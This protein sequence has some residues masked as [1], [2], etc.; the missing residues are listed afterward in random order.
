MEELLNPTTEGQEP[1]VE[2]STEP[3]A[4]PV[5]GESVSAEP[6]EQQTKETK[7]AQSPEENA[8]YAAARRKAE[9]EKAE[10]IQ[11]AKDEFASTIAKRAGIENV[12]S[13]SDFENYLNDLELKAS[14]IDPE[15]YQKLRDSDPEVRRAK[16][17]LAQQEQAQKDLQS[18]TDFVSVFKEA[19]GREFDP[20]TDK[21]TYAEVKKDADETGRD[22]SDVFARRH[23]KT[24]MQRLAELEAKLNEQETNKANAATSP[25]SV[26][27]D[28]ETAGGADYISPEAFE[29]NRK[30][31]EW[32]RRN[33]DKI[34]KSRPK[35]GG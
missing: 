17:V 11:K 23:S 10:A 13:A 2:A 28:G 22:I 34:L 26:A 15:T 9:A 6:A 12:Q 8:K 5:T 32:V 4:E 24:L 14:G 27:S 19:N 16:E 3:A 31:A 25:G 7:A 33:Y 21:S 30:D 1:V 29:Q 20:A 18:F 35:W